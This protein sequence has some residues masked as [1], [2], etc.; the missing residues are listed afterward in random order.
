[1]A[2]QLFDNIGASNVAEQN[3]V[4]Q[5]SGSNI[6]DLNSLYSPSPSISNDINLEIHPSLSQFNLTPDSGLG[7]N[8]KVTNQYND[9]PKLNYIDQLKWDGENPYADI[10][11]YQDPYKIAAPY[12]F[13]AEK[14]NL[15]RYM[16]YGQ[17][18]FNRIGFNPTANNEE[19]FNQET[20]IFND[21]ARAAVPFTN[22]VVSGAMNSARSWSDVVNGDIFNTDDKS[23]SEF[24]KAMDI[25]MSSRGGVGGFLS[26]LG[27]NFAYT[28]G[29]IGEI[30][31]EEAAIAAGSVLLSGETAGLSLLEGASLMAR[32]GIQGA[33]QAM[34]FRQIGDMYKG[35]KSFLQSLRNINEAE[36]LY[37]EAR[38]GAAEFT[39]AAGEFINP[40]TRTTEF[41]SN[42]KKGEAGLTNMAKISSGFGSFYRDIR[43]INFSLAEG[44]LEGGSAKQETIDNLSQ[45]YFEKNGSYPAGD[46]LKKI[47][48]TADKVGYATTL[49]NLPTIYY[50]NKITLDGMFN[51]KGI[52]GVIADAE[53]A[54]SGII[55][56]RAAGFTEDAFSA[57]EKSATKRMFSNLTSPKYYLGTGLG[58]FKRNFAEGIQES[59]QDVISN[60]AK[61]YYT[62]IY[63]DKSMGGLNLMMS[64]LGNGFSGQF[65][66]QGA[67]TFLSGFLMGGLMSKSQNLLFKTLPN[68]Y[69]S[70]FNKE[71][72]KEYQET[73]KQSIEDTVT[74][75]NALRK[76]ALDP[77]NQTM[78]SD[79]AKFF[80]P[81]L[82]SL[83][84]QINAGSAVNAAIQQNDDNNYH[85]AKDFQLFDHIHT[86]LRTGTYDM[87]MESLSDLKQLSSKDLAQA[88]NVQDENKAV[89]KLTDVIN[90]ANTIQKKYNLIQSTYVNPFKPK[91]F[92]KGTPD[93]NKEAIAFR[94]FENAKRDLLLATHSFDRSLDRMVGILDDLSQNKPLSKSS[95]T[96]ISVLFEARKIDDEISML[97][98]EI[99]TLDGKDPESKKLKKQKEDKLSYLKKY[100]EKL[101]NHQ[102][103]HAT[104]LY[105]MSKPGTQQT[106]FGSDDSKLVKAAEELKEAYKEYLKHIAEQS[107][108]FVFDNKV[109][110][111][112]KK[113]LDYYTLYADSKNL[114]NIV[115]TL[116]NPTNL[117]RHAQ[118]INE[119]LTEIFD[120]KDEFTMNNVVAM[121][122]SMELNQI[123][124]QLA[125]L[126]IVIDEQDLVNYVKEGT[127]PKDFYSSITQK[128]IP[129][130]SDLYNQALA[131][132][133]LDTKIANDEDITDDDIN[134][135][136]AQQTTAEPTQTTPTQPEGA[137]GEEGI[138]EEPTPTETTPTMDPAL[139]KELRAAYD[140]YVADP[141]V[142]EPLAFEDFII[143][144]PRAIR[145]KTSFEKKNK[146]EEPPTGG[147]APV[148]EPTTTVETKPVETSD[149]EAKKA[150]IEKDVNGEF[151]PKKYTLNAR[152][153]NP[154]PNI[155]ISAID[156]QDSGLQDLTDVKQV[157][158]LEIR[159]KNSEGK[160]VGKVWIQKKDGQ[161][162][163]AEVKFNDAELAALNAKPAETAPTQSK[164]DEIK[165]LKLERMSLMSDES[166]TS[167]ERL[168]AINTRLEELGEPAL[169]VSEVRTAKELVGVDKAKEAISKYEIRDLRDVDSILDSMITNDEITGLDADRIL[170]EWKENAIKNFNKNSVKPGDIVIFVGGGTGIVVKV[171]ENSVTIKTDK[172]QPAKAMEFKDLQSSVKDIK[173]GKEKI[174]AVEAEVV[175]AQ[176]TE[177]LNESRDVLKD[178]LKDKDKMAQAVEEGKKLSE[179]DALNNILDNLG[180]DI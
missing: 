103:A 97:T 133:N 179:A 83:V 12:K 108:D 27:L 41:A 156:L 64:S 129:Y 43:D 126:N 13:D 111:S 172:D 46:D 170:N 167:A 2:E 28:I 131:I 63:N 62:S 105:E 171:N 154:A 115:N 22:L 73:R 21:L 36:K 3:V 100:Q 166:G 162:F 136:T 178:V 17:S 135:I 176:E 67:E 120:K 60:T 141:N 137:V 124:N 68:L 19:R 117:V 72:Y 163:D 92:K 7:N 130:A 138:Q 116:M 35:G 49:A 33:Q 70:T 34:K 6:M 4:P 125:A 80:D 140:Q 148:A 96:D 77:T 10:N 74:S 79:P 15:D 132:F 14:T 54:A 150:D 76:A 55:T 40:F 99:K 71:Q 29:T 50:S 38:A 119:V 85:N 180:C 56:N 149:I 159:G 37:S 98:K 47:L 24:K 94:S 127:I 90:S 86:V 93:Y 161:S 106:L 84:N 51:F 30:F 23:A 39:R 66:A 9:T 110:E 18:T 52:G 175:S 61:D 81:K 25:G 88:M 101:E 112:F 45:E 134:P 78:F 151:I 57:A 164:E 82:E 1:M 155:S 168:A 153:E 53:N 121:M 157:K 169:Q 158:L 104:H 145:I 165:A 26:N 102:A 91:N 146:P 114:A 142:D 69:Q 109:D 16:A 174:E 75:L 173:H 95:A 20:N 58:Y 31:A 123:V 5:D 107:G 147:A 89:E 139:E 118:G 128:K 144:N 122:R 65:S 177:T 160:T 11:K 59:L 152:G 42:L 44:K 32:R 143:G 87:F 48:D 113:I 8:I